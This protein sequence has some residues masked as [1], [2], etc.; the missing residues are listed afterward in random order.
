MLSLDV[1][2][3][4]QRFIQMLDPER[5]RHFSSLPARFPGS[6]HQFA[7]PSVNIAGTTKPNSK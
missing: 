3:R 6:S 1:T 4:A 2:R 7:A 5:L